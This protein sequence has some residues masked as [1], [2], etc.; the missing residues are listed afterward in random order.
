MPKSMEFKFNDQ[1]TNTVSSNDNTFIIQ[2]SNDSSWTTVCTVTDSDQN[3]SASSDS[4]RQYQI[5]KQL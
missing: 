4:L 5:Q 2:G 3:F 1:Y